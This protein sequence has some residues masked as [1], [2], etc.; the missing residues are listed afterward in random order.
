[1]EY[2]YYY[3]VEGIMKGEKKELKNVRNRLDYLLSAMKMD[4]K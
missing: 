1:M 2:P 3:L 4:L